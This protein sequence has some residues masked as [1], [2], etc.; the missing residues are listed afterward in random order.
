MNEQYL[1]KVIAALDTSG[2]KVDYEKIKQTINKNPMMTKLG[3][4]SSVTK[5]QVKELADVI[6]K[7]LDGIFKN[8]GV[9]DLKVSVKEVESIINGT[10]KQAQ[11]D[12]I[13]RQ[14]QI[15]KEIQKQQEILKVNSS[16]NQQNKNNKHIQ[17][18]NTLLLSQQKEYQSI[19]NINKKIAKLD[20]NKNSKEIQSLQEEKRHRQD[21]YNTLQK[22]LSSYSN[23]IDNQSKLNNLLNIS[24]KS[25]LE[26]NNTK[27][28]ESDT[29]SN[30]LAKD[31]EQAYKI[32][33]KLSD[34][35]DIIKNRAEGA[36]AG[37]NSYLKSLKPEALSTYSQEID[38]ISKSFYK[39]SESGKSID[40]TKAN[41]QL[42]KF[43]NEMKDTG[44]ET[45]SFSQL[46]KE[47]IS[48]FTNWYLIGG[49]VSTLIGKFKKSIVEIKEVNTFLTEISKTSELTGNQLKQLGIN[50]YDY[51][52]KY[53]ETAQNYLGGFLEMNRAGFDNSKEM[54]DLSILAQSAGDMSAEIANNYLIATDAAYKF[55]GN[56]QELSKVLDGQ[57]KVSN[58]TAIEMTD[59]A[60]ATSKAASISAEYG[61]KVNELTALIAVAGSKTRQSGEEVGN[62][63]KSIF[64]NL[65]N[66]SSS[67]ISDTFDEVGISMTKI[68]DGSERLKTP[69]ELIKELSDVFT[70]LEEGS[71]KKADILTNIGGKY[72]AN[73][74]SSILSGYGD[75]E[76]ILE[77][78]SSGIGSA[79][80]EAEKSANSIEGKLN[81][82]SNAWNQTVANVID[83][84]LLKGLIDIGTSAVDLADD[85]NLLKTAIFG[86]SI[87]GSLKGGKALISWF[88]N[89]TESTINFGNALNSIKSIDKT[90]DWNGL[91]KSIESL[92][93]SQLDATLNTKELS[94]ETIDF[95]NAMQAVNMVESL[96]DYDALGRAIKGLSA[97][98][99]VA[100]L[101]TKG[102]NAESI[103]LALTYA[104]LTTKEEATAVATNL[105]TT[106]T[107]TATTANVG[108]ATSFKALTAAIASNSIG[109][110]IT[111]ITVAVS[112]LSLGINKYNQSQQEMLD[113][114]TESTSV[115]NEQTKSITEYESKIKSLRESLDSG[116][117]SIEGQTSA[118]E[119][120]I[121]IQNDLIKT[122]GIEKSGLDLVNGSIDEQ[123]TKLQELNK[124]KANTYLAENQKA[125]N[126]YNNYLTEQKS[127]DIGGFTGLKLSD[128][129]TKYLSNYDDGISTRI[130]GDRTG[131]TFMM[132]KVEVTI[133]QTSVEDAK[134]KLEKLYADINDEFGNSKDAEKVKLAISEVLNEDIDT[135]KIKEARESVDSY[136]QQQIIANDK[137][138]PLYRESAQ[139]IEEYNNAI[140]SGK[141]INEAKT[142]LDNIKKKVYG[143]TDA[144]KG[145]ENVFNNLFDNIS[146]GSAK[147]SQ[148]M[149][150]LEEKAKS[151][152]TIGS[153]SIFYTGDEDNENTLDSFQENIQK[154]KSAI[155]SLN[156]GELTQSD[157][158]DLMQELGIDSSKVDLATNSFVGLKEALQNIANAELQ[159]M[160][161]TLKNALDNKDI[162][163]STYYNLANAFRDMASDANRASSSIMSLSD[164][165][166]TLNSHQSMI[167]DLKDEIK[168]TKK[169]SGDTVSELMQSYPQLTDVLIEYQQ[170]L[171]STN[172]VLDQLKIAYQNDVENYKLAIIEKQSTSIQ[173][174]NAIGKN[175][176]G[177]FNQYKENYNTDLNNFK[178]LAQA[179]ADVEASLIG[180]LGHN[181]ADYYDAT[182]GKITENF[183]NLSDAEKAYASKAVAKSKSLRSISLNSVSL[184]N[185]SF[186][187]IKN[188]LKGKKD[189][190]K[191]END[192]SNQIDWNAQSIEN[193]KRKLDELN[194]ALD[195]TTSLDGQISKYKELINTQ[196][197][198]QKA[199]SNSANLYKKAYNST[200]GE[201]SKKQKSKYKNLIQSGSTF[202]IEDFKGK[203]GEKL[204]DTVTKAQD[205]YKSWKDNA[206]GAKEAGYSISQFADELVDVRWDKATESVNSLNNS[207]DLLNDK[208]NNAT[209]WK[210]RNTLLE[211][212]LKKQKQIVNT[213][214]DAVVGNQ[215]DAS[216]TFS[217]INKKYRKD[218]KGKTVKL[219]S[220]ISTKGVTNK[221]QLALIKQYNEHVK[222]LRENTILLKSE[223]EKYN[224]TLAE[225]AQAQFD[226]IASDYA[227]K[228]KTL[229]NKQ[230]QIQN[231]I[232]IAEAQ[233]RAVGKAYYEELIKI[234]KQSLTKSQEELSKLQSKLDKSVNN[235]SVEKYSSTW[236]DMV[237]EIYDTRDAIDQSTISI[238]GFSDSIQQI[239]YDA[240]DKLIEK[241]NTL[242]SESN[243]LIGLMDSSK[244]INEDGSYTSNGLATQGLYAQNYD[245][246]LYEAE[247]YK[248][249]IVD[250]DKEYS[251]DRN[252]QKYLS[253]RESFLEAQR[254]AIESANSE[255]D[256]LISLAQEGIQ[257][258]IDAETELIKVKKDALSA[259]KDL[260]EYQKSIA[261]KTKNIAKIQKQIN[262][263][264]GDDS[265][266]NRKKLQQLKASLKEAQDDLDDTT[267]SKS[268]EMQQ[269]S[270]DKDIENITKVMTAYS[271][272]T[273]QLFND[274]LSKINSSSTSISA[275][276]TKTAST[277][278][279]SISS[280]IS[281][282]WKT[283]GNSV[284]SYANTL[285]TASSGIIA[286]LTSIKKVYDEMNESAEL[287][288]TASVKAIN[289]T[290]TKTTGAS[291][292]VEDILGTKSKANGASNRGGSNL[293]LWLADQGYKAIS[294]GNMVKLAKLLGVDGINTT[295]DV[296]FGSTKSA[297]NTGNVLEALKKY[298]KGFSSGGVATGINKIIGNNGDD[299]LTTIKVGETT[300]TDKFTELMP[301]AVDTMDLLN[302]NNVQN[303]LDNLTKVNIPDNSTITSKTTQP[304]VNLEVNT[305]LIH[306]DNMDENMLYKLK[307]DTTIQKT[308]QE[309]TIGKMVSG[310]F[311]SGARW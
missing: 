288:A 179:K 172:D 48:A 136:V 160:I 290:N 203:S 308:I 3:I 66:T 270:Y 258:Q 70:S 42:S 27:S 51:A 105:M 268:I 97:E 46:I 106:A 255:K 218:S 168:E 135:S 159:R 156:S 20:P 9:D 86:L 303:M 239:K 108:L 304:S 222:E 34:S 7:S 116:S 273:E 185:I 32:N 166:S 84:D 21:S 295:A 195:N 43:K 120:L 59:I 196:T 60:S 204:Y 183:A 205:L 194:S 63:L 170:G 311:N 30:R 293:N 263:L 186:D 33:Q 182:T 294:T 229:D 247:Q 22:Q 232:D 301:T 55:K 206:Q 64:V 211:Q 35:M 144:V 94:A 85:M 96:S 272:D 4:D 254:S 153:L 127:Y 216:D 71:V 74:L 237:Q 246:Y 220:L 287:S 6:H 73:V 52:S 175:N 279:Y 81:K 213:Y 286:T 16:K 122:Y 54:A 202:K 271:E 302:N 251:N 93:K 113:K 8:A 292:T 238:E 198:L 241:F 169:I 90:K 67:K 91:A 72:Q 158:L 233:G 95:G 49:A 212:I 187:S 18:A 123:I 36:S 207:I 230:N 210:A 277:V 15:T 145:S 115:I 87:V 13:N 192:F 133:D 79:E 150:D 310:A 163:E 305:P 47:N 162:D 117:L 98:Q 99:A 224:T 200:L 181:W 137:L 225:T 262:A 23:I 19:W 245:T 125:Y 104:G 157:V 75:Y 164:A 132:G 57:N 11:K 83:S 275:T 102:L 234:E 89:A 299:A 128:E 278:G 62:S 285:T 307:N 217:Q 177:L 282:A 69:I 68:V 227:N 130:M 10:L 208:L 274:T 289:T 260:Y 256:A 139:A 265:E 124:E 236:Y 235:G 140:A 121:S 174:W 188:D 276:L 296:A 221:N 264:E 284:T 280:N 56:A 199:Y 2:I 180:A 119:E 231:Q 143:N 243:F 131:E 228:Q 250:L 178:S 110:I 193:L 134:Q 167:A 88:Q 24:K 267:Y 142:N 190:S 154:I 146:D 147:A 191:K 240:L 215:D 65:Q 53:G 266:E 37:F 78:Y 114:M 141:S 259:E 197:E 80:E 45:A 253:Q 298:L 17:E 223:Q 297:T 152:Q 248:Q 31:E 126:K 76:K 77:M 171:S 39:A 29:Y 300:L 25:Q 61:V 92:S 226:N 252:N 44:M 1:L 109:F 38:K 155:Q 249:A 281:D 40:L 26:I 41:S 118:K 309:M 219:G 161:D 138:R 5:Q 100:L 12:E 244:L 201:L 14:K 103:G 173:F 291:Y 129:M 107:T 165:L 283:A 149:N 306:V 112:A 269:D 151:I 82:L 257:A 50:T 101:S 242:T 58:E 176:A 261:E 28:K 189:K 209:S 148:S 214:S 111:G 184:K